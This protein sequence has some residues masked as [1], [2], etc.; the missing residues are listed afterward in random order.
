[1][2]YALTGALLLAFLFCLWLMRRGWRRRAERHADLPVLPVPPE[3]TGD[4]VVP[5][6]E[7][8]YLGTTEAGAWLERVTAQG[9]GGRAD[10]SLRLVPEGLVVLREGEPDAFVP[11]ADLLGAEV[12]DAQAGKWIGEGGVLLVTWRLGGIDVDSGFRAHDHS[13][14]GVW[15]SAV[16]ALAPALPATPVARA[17]AAPVE[18]APPAPTVAKPAPPAPAPPVVP[19]VARPAAPA[20]L[21]RAVPPALLV[22][23]DGRSF[24]GTAYGA[25][26]E[27]F[28]EAVFNTGMTGYQETLTD[29]S[30]HRQVVVQTAPHIGNTGVN[31]YDDESGRI[32]VAGYVVRDPA[33]VAS[34]WRAERGL[35][36]EL[37]RQGIVGIG[38][39]DTRAVTRHLRD[40]GAMRC[41]VSSTGETA[42]EVLAKVLAS[43]SMAGADLAREVST[44]QPY[45]VPAN[46]E[47]RF[48]VAALDLGMKRSIPA[49]LAYFG[50]EVHVLPATA[51]ADDI[52]ATDPDG[53]FLSNGPGDPA[54]T[55]YAVEALRGV[56]GRRPVFGICLGHQLLGRALGLG[57]YKLTF[58]HRGVNQP[59][60]DVETKRVAITSHNH[61]FAVALPDSPATAFGHVEVSHVDL[62]DGVVE[63]LRCRDVPAFSVQFHPEAA[64]G[65]HDSTGLFE[66]FTDLMATGVR[67]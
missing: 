56:L 40:K 42:D 2:R 7:G 66:A 63:G 16:N 57:T 6:L 8:L 10:A 60:Q 53:V 28:G 19:P 39:V 27:T 43:P 18:A 44:P 46:G 54:A 67:L 20:L 24:T 45:V 26:G 23:E 9:L 48:R 62:N 21:G 50:C 13:L 47:R 61:G 12:T 3:T 55:Q 59:V 35:D 52:L 37:K 15:A 5:P 65:P 36:G 1:M 31:A 29:P 11:R 34:S 41:A 25:V 38:G 14:H 33:R 49:Y 30:Y 4:D 22:L 51:T 32:W 64:A 58:G 17:E